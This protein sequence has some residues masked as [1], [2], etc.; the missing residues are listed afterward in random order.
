M[1]V[2]GIAV[3]VIGL[4]SV[5]AM[6]TGALATGTRPGQ[7]HQDRQGELEDIVQA[8]LSELERRSRQR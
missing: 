1:I 6:L 7:P 2:I 3:G 5:C 8:V 4:C